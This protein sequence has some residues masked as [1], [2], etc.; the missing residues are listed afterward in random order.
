MLNA[1]ARARAW[2]RR[3]RSWPRPRRRAAGLMWR[4]QD[5]SMKLHIRLF[6]K[7]ERPDRYVAARRTSLHLHLAQAVEAVLVGRGGLKC[8]IANHIDQ[9]VAN[10]DLIGA[11]AEGAV[12]HAFIA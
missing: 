8:R 9:R 11:Q 6:L 7:P 1:A 4:G 5:M 3:S 12:Q 2:L 10:R